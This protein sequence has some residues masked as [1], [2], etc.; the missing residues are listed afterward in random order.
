MKW[1]K[2]AKRLLL[3]LLAA[4]MVFYG[5]GCGKQLS[6]E[7]NKEKESVTENEAVQKNDEES[8]TPVYEALPEL[9]TWE[10]VKIKSSG[11]KEGNAVLLEEGISI[12]YDETLGQN[13]LK[14]TGE[15]GYVKLPKDIWQDAADGFTV[16]FLVKPETDSDAGAKLFQTNLCGYGAGDLQWR[17]APEL[18]ITAGGSIRIYVGGRTINGTYNA[19]ATYNNGGSG[20]DKDYAEPGGHK[21]RYSGT[22]SAFAADTW[23]EVVL[24]VS[25][26]EMNLYVNGEKVN[27]KENAAE[28][29]NLTSSL[30]YLFGTYAGGERILTQYVNS[31]I[32]NS[33]YSDTKNFQGLLANLRIYTEA[34]TAEEITE[35]TAA[36]AW[37][38]DTADLVYGETEEEALAN[39]PFYKGGEMLSEVKNLRVTSPDEKTLVQFWRAT[40]GSFYYSVTD[41]G[42]VLVESSAIGLVLEEAELGSGLDI[43]AGSESRQTIQETYELLTGRSTTAENYCKELRFTLTGESGSF[44][45]VFRVFDDGVAYKYE[46]VTVDGYEQVVVTKEC[47]EI[48]FPE[49][50]VSW[51]Y[52][53]NGTYE[54]EY[55]KRSSSQLEALNAKLSTPMLVKEKEYWIL[56]TEAGVFN[57]NGD[58]CSSG[59]KTESGERALRWAFGLD[60]DP[61]RESTGELDSPGHIDITEVTTRSGFAT[62]WRVLVISDDLEEFCGSTIV[63]D[64][65]PAPDEELFA[66]TGWI[67]PGKVAWSWWA[68]E[69]AQKDYDK[70]V[71]YIDFALENGWEYV[72]LDAGW[73][74]FERR[75]PELCQY[76]EEKGVGIFVWVNYRDLRN[77]DE[78]ESLFTGWKEAGVV[79]LKTDY[80]ESDAQNVL[81]TMEQVAITCAEKQLMVLYHGCVRPAGESRTYPNIL[82][83][84]AVLGEEAHKWS[85]LPTIQ[86]CLLYP[87]TRNICGSM[88]YTPAATKVGSNEST[89]G[90]GLAMTVV[91]ESG[92]QHLAY[93]ASSYKTYLGLPFLNHLEVTWEESKLI[94]GYPG[95]Y[96]TVARRNGENWYI[97]AMTA[98]GRTALVSLDFLADGEYHAYLYHDSEDGTR[99]LLEETMVTKNDT[100]ELVLPYAGGAAVLITKDVID[101]TVEAAE[102]GGLADFICYEAEA[103]EN[104]LKGA[105][106][107]QSSAFCS[108][109]RKVGYIG[110]SGNTLTFNNITV[111]KDGT[112]KLLLYY[113]SGETRKVILTVNGDTMY[114]MRGLNSGDYVHTKAAEITVELKAGKNTIMISNPTYYAPDIDRIAISKQPE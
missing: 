94:E 110:Y 114:E 24:S 52:V 105:A 64:L 83:T 79:G 111:E 71:E 99:L 58:Y 49:T 44:D 77:F 74:A 1:G 59:L 80:F 85:A 25:S 45:L 75:L 30:E 26:K 61:K 78:M 9:V 15:D 13:A 68:E 96:I 107:T 23:T 14:M 46:N 81:K 7:A 35:K 27:V 42:I 41:D 22:A 28:E 38:F 43:K 113:C 70:H 16:A 6:E 87:F 72:C 84:E 67:R 86:N 104:T 4:D 98:E 20:D 21:T 60:R 53:I 100:L 3:L 47:S 57:N 29:G 66:D 90:F 88:D 102:D 31:S 10:G 36:Y 5:T 33:V 97:G 63:T 39:L 92:L 54:A 32:G 106:V 112:Y 56:V 89:Y 108:G 91:Y 55:V 95:E 73:R 12:V 109:G 37:D 93:A 40:D 62:P 2:K 69:A 11:T 18:S 48:I 17:D 103:A 8:V 65:N 76:A 34:M 82:T 101:T 19:L 50:A 51:S